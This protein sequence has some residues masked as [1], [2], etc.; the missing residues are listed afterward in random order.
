[1]NQSATMENQAVNFENAVIP[2]SVVRRFFQREQADAHLIAKLRN[3]ISSLQSSLHNSGW[4][5]QH[6]IVE[7]NALS[8]YY[9][10]LHRDYLK[11]FEAYEH[12]EKRINYTQPRI[13]DLPLK[14]R[15]TSEDI[16]T[17]NA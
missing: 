10:Q 14:E 11:L 12:L 4:R 7:K 13:T 1:M 9:D 2:L 16:I 15:L 3:E 5:M 17:E 8:T 6:V